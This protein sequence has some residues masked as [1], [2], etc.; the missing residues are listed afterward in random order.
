MPPLSGASP[1]ETG[2]GGPCGAWWKG[3]LER[4]GNTNKKL[5]YESNDFMQQPFLFVDY[6][7]L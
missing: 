6:K 4:L 7:M 1:V 2:G 3:R 5:L